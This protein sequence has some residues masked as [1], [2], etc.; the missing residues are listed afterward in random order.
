LTPEESQ[1]FKIQAQE[2][3]KVRLFEEMANASAPSE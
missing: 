1:N 3:D 2:N